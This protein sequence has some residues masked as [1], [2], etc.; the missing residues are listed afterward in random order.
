[1]K[2]FTP[3]EADFGGGEDAESDGVSFLRDDVVLDE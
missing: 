2:A 3:G 1:M